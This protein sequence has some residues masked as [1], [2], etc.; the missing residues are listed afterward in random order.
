M[1]GGP[2]P[3]PVHDTGAGVLHDGVRKEIHRNDLRAAR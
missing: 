2:P 3:G 1:A